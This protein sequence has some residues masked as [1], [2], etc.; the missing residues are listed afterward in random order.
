MMRGLLF[1]LQLLFWLLV[2]RLVARALARV[3]LAFTAGS[4]ASRPK[5]PPAAPPR[6]IEDLVLDHVCQTH[7]P[8]SRALVA[9]VRGRE[10]HFC[11]EAC[12]DKA[13]AGTAPPSA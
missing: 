11:S 10:E 7:L 13:L 2:A 9:T 3:F 4:P 6:R 12:R 1:V 8:R 5:A